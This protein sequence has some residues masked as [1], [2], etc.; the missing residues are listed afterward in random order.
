MSKYNMAMS[1]WKQL[2]NKPGGRWIFSQIVCWKAPYFATISPRFVELRPGYCEVH[3]NKRRRVL[4]HLKTIH[5]IAMCNMAELVAGTMTDVT[6]P[7]SHRWI[8]KG[9][10]VK[11]IK[12]AMTKLHAIAELNPIPKFNDAVTLP[13]TVKIFDTNNEV[14]FQAVIE[15]W[16]SPRNR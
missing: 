8:P 16:V 10:K 2:S 5:A 13:V 11:Y 3:M 1:A 12:K 6:I 15:M 4:N 9:M 7:T 14:V